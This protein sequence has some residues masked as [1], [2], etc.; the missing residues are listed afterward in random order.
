MD[1]IVVNQQLDAKVESPSELKD[2]LRNLDKEIDRLTEL[3]PKLFDKLLKKFEEYQNQINQWGHTEK[4][5]ELDD[6]QADLLTQIKHDFLDLYHD[7]VRFQRL[8]S[9]Y[10]DAKG[11]VI[12]DIGNNPIAEK[13]AAKEGAHTFES[14][15]LAQD[16]AIFEKY[17]EFARANPAFLKF[18]N[19]LYYG[20]PASEDN[21]A[22]AY[23]Q[24]ENIEE[25]D[26]PANLM[27][28]H[29]QMRKAN[30]AAHEL[31]LEYCRQH[32][33][34]PKKQVAFVPSEQFS[35]G[36]HAG[37]ED[38]ETR[39]DTWHTYVVV[40]TDKSGNGMKFVNQENGKA[41]YIPPYITAL[42]ETGHVQ[43]YKMFQKRG[44]SPP[45]GIN[46]IAQVITAV[47]N[48][49]HVYKKINNLALDMTVEYPKNL[50]SDKKDGI[51]LGLL[52]NTFREL[53]KKHG[54]IEAALMSKEGQTFVFS[55][56]DNAV[57]RPHEISINSI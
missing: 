41:Y 37:I 35:F 43:R 21:P 5:G 22:H 26:L 7:L 9:D 20:T 1:E 6:K 32:N 27:I 4:N 28:P 52:A 57:K 42:H 55:Y 31:Y 17:A 11:K 34:D 46:E 40:E 51:H 53:L 19:A 18:G 36:G 56:Y 3:N 39:E 10:Q 29:E 16:A 13:L 50:P 45:N 2:T 33:L 8:N 44:E 14:R 47:I 25:L 49:D 48:M 23:T 24:I 15:L 12:F 54:T 38:R 30:T